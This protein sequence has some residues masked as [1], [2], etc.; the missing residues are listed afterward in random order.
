MK[1]KFVI[2]LLWASFG[3]TIA[4]SCITVGTACDDTYL[5]CYDCLDG[6]CGP[7]ELSQGIYRIPYID[8]TNV[9]ITNDHYNHCPRGRI[10]MIGDGGTSSPFGIAAAADGW[11]RA[12]EEDNDERCDCSVTSCANNYVWIE[13]PNGEWSKYTHMIQNSVS[14]AGIEVGDWVT[15]GTLIGKEGE[16]GCASGVHLHFEVAVPI[17]TNT[18]IFSAYGGWIDEDWAKNVIPVICSISGNVFADGVEYLADD[19]GVCISSLIN[20]PETITS[21]EFDADIASVS[22]TAGAVIFD[23]YSSGLY[24]AGSFINL[25]EGFEAKQ[26]S[27]FTA[28]IATCNETPG[29]TSA[30]LF[31]NEY[32]EIFLFPNPASTSVTL[33]W[34][35]NMEQ[36]CAIY[37]ADI[38]GRIITTIAEEQMCYSG[39]NQINFDVSGLEDGMYFLQLQSKFKTRTIKLIVQQ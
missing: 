15:A 28:R 8:G 33:R 19:C 25:S 27:E 38:T 7:F 31:E 12:I 9:E 26:N 32:A 35:D 18:L 39:F 6:N 29:K 5:Y 24:Q 23:D 1:I 3:Y 37:I 14:A 21:G 34:F 4:Q 2:A 17:D 20:L 16:V 36:K 22:I 11:I 13:H 10:D 30:T